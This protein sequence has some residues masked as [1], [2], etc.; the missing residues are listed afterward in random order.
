[1][2]I[3]MVFWLIC[4]NVPVMHSTIIDAYKLHAQ[5]LHATVWEKKIGAH[6]VLIAWDSKVRILQQQQQQLENHIDSILIKVKIAKHSTTLKICHVEIYAAATN[7]E[8]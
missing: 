7:C 8:I 4:V 1:M 2:Q 5:L 6:Y 3:K